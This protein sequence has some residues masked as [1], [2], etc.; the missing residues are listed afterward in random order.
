MNLRVP[1]L[2]MWCKHYVATETPRAACDAFLDGIPMAIFEE[3]QQ[4]RTP[5]PGDK[6]L[7][8]VLRDPE[9]DAEF[10]NRLLGML[11]KAPLTQEEF[12]GSDR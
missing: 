3:G 8:F 2:C 12:G 5:W 11:R 10:V 7:R 1:P 4:H 9:G 6:G